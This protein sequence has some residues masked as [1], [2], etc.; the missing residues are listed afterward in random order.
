MTRIMTLA[1]I[2]NDWTRPVSRIYTGLECGCRC[3]CHGRYFEPG[4]IGFTRAMNKARKLDPEVTET[5]DYATSG[6]LINEQKWHDHDGK[7]AAHAYRYAAPD[8]NGI[9]EWVDICD[10]NGK[11]ITLYLKD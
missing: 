4:S 2:L 1:R 3:G 5:D 9:T 10:G 6:K 7:V 11:T 8:S